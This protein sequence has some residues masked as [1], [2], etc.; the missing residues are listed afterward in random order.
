MVSYR[1]PAA[2][3]TVISTDFFYNVGP[4]RLEKIVVVSLYIWVC[5]PRVYIEN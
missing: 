1:Q 3:N 4:T 2:S 5:L